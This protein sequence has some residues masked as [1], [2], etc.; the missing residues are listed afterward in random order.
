MYIDSKFNNIK[1]ETS[2]IVPFEYAS[3][4]QDQMTVKL[5]KNARIPHNDLLKTRPASGDIEYVN[6]AKVSND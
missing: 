2:L 6:L 4:N 1:I 5:H 3:K